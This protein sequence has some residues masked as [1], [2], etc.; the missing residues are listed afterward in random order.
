MSFVA[1]DKL[2]NQE[3]L[4]DYLGPRMAPFEVTKQL[5]ILCMMGCR[6]HWEH[7]QELLELITLFEMPLY[8]CTGHHIIAALNRID[9]EL[10]STGAGEH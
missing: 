7:L 2:F 10:S 4:V 8:Q 5:P 3:S 1:I 9:C 6:N